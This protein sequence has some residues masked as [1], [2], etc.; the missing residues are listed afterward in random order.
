MNNH[1]TDDGKLQG[2][3][4]KSGTHPCA[5]LPLFG[6]LLAALV[7]AAHALVALAGMAIAVRAHADGVELADVPVAVM[8]AGGHGATNGLI[9]AD[10][11]H[12]VF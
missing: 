3:A 2:R 10:S 9:H 6:L 8:A 1:I 4:R 5:P 7:G 12:V 11:L